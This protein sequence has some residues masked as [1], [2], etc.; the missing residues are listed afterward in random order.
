MFTIDVR[1]SIPVFI[2]RPYYLIYESGMRRCCLGVL[3]L[4]ALLHGPPAVARSPDPCIV[5]G[6]GVHVYRGRSCV[7]VPFA[8]FNQSSG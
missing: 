6:C 4:T 8:C 2:C 1:V 5:G 3:W 7:D